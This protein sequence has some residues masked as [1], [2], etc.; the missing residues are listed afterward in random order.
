MVEALRISYRMYRK[1]SGF[2]FRKRER[3]SC[4]GAADTFINTSSLTEGGVSSGLW[5]LDGGTAVVDEVERLDGLGLVGS[6]GSS[7]LRGGGVPEQGT[8]HGDL[9]TAAAAAA[10]GV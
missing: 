6:P 8:S 2:H 4:G 7:Q 9:A 3:W 5:A 10:V 1:A